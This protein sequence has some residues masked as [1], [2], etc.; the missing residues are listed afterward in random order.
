M[1]TA[2]STRAPSSTYPMIR[3]LRS[4]VLLDNNVNIKHP[5]EL[6]PCHRTVEREVAQNF[7]YSFD[8]GLLSFP[9]VSGFYALPVFKTEV[10][11]VRTVH[12]LVSMAGIMMSKDSVGASLRTWISSLL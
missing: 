12:S 1:R 8:P 7:D 6:R 5:I 2:R 10:V 9:V 11:L 4:I 3:T